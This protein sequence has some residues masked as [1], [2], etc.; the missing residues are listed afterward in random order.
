[1]C[2][3]IDWTTS[4]QTQRRVS[5]VCA[6]RFQ[7]VVVTATAAWAPRAATRA[8]RLEAA[9]GKFA[10]IA[11]RCEADAF[12]WPT[13]RA[14]KHRFSTPTHKWCESVQALFTR[15][16]YFSILGLARGAPMRILIYANGRVRHSA[17]SARYGPSS[18]YYVPPR[19]G[20]ACD[21][22]TRRHWRSTSCFFGSANVVD[23]G[24]DV[25]CDEA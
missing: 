10:G 3:E 15:G 19:T 18:S 8:V 12:Y 9:A 21:P 17:W 13:T 14:S 20:L 5:A 25:D 23:S 22:S 7:I 6:G 24:S 2:P 4:L 1:M 16:T 11:A